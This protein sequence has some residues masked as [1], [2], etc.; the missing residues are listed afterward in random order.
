MSNVFLLQF[1]V[2]L[3]ACTFAVRH[4]LQLEDSWLGKSA[5]WCAS[6]DRSIGCDEDSV[7]HVRSAF[8]NRR[9]R[10]SCEPLESGTEMS[11]G[12]NATDRVVK[13]CGNKQR[14]TLTA[15]DHA[16]CPQ[17]P[18]S[19]IRVVW[20]CVA[21]PVTSQEKETREVEAS[22]EDDDTTEE[23]E[24]D[25][26][27]A[28][29]DQ[30]ADDELADSLP[31]EWH[32]TSEG[33]PSE[34]H[35]FSKVLPSTPPNRSKAV[36]SK[37]PKASKASDDDNHEDWTSAFGKSAVWCASAGHRIAC[38][39]E[40]VI[41]I[42]SAFFNRRK[43]ASCMPLKSGGKAGCRP[44]VTDMV[45]GV[46]ENTKSCKLTPAHHAAC[47]KKPF[48]LIRVVW[49][50]I[51][52]P[53]STTPKVINKAALDQPTKKERGS[54]SKNPDF[55]LELVPCYRHT[56]TH[57]ISE[58]NFFGRLTNCH[59]HEGC[60]KLNFP[61]GKVFADPAVPPTEEELESGEVVKGKDSKWV[62]WKGIGLKR[63]DYNTWGLCLP[64][65]E[66]LDFAITIF[67]NIK[68]MS[69]SN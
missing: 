44:N 49:D 58:F 36:P 57:L 21:S 33:L 14:C 11:C 56:R 30:P 8:F 32:E 35:P 48:S 62:T 29:P 50:C 23:S 40:S 7:I 51:A 12:P 24:M 28:G 25:V 54:A 17:H 53:A 67:D 37:P 9:L 2:G 1:L 18:Y 66:G 39:G 10:K 64:K 26:G 60:F 68:A 16:A 43:R 22:E 46:C 5:I 15:R 42:R 3:P 13:Q 55:S 63:N 34:Q 61:G 38:A 52:N 59:E 65:D 6:K 69:H 27:N 41:H 20:E 4:Q 19:L 31:S 47:A 45:T